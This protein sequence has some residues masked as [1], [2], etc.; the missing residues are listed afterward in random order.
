MRNRPVRRHGAVFSVLHG[1]L[2]DFYTLSECIIYR[3]FAA[4]RMTWVRFVVILSGAKDLYTAF[5]NSAEW[6]YSYRVSEIP[7]VS[8][9]SQFCEYADA[10]EVLPSPLGEERV[11]SEMGPV[12]HGRAPVVWLAR[13]ARRKRSLPGRNN[14]SADCVGTSPYT[15]EAGGRRDGPAV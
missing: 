5:V 11:F 10:G 3:S 15:G 2:W 8:V 6:K 12:A 7:R 13:S 1:R 14:P 4:L 9:K